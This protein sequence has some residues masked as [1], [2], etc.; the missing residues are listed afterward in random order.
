MLCRVL[1]QDVP[2][3]DDSYHCCNQDYPCDPEN[4]K[5]HLGREERGEVI[6]H[7]T[8]QVCS[9][10]RFQDLVEVKQNAWCFKA[11]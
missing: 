1:A 11:Q 2:C 4:R 3:H 8:C 10:Y 7:Y 9:V 6:D 5:H